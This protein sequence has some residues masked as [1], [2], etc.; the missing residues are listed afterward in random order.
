MSRVVYR[1]NRQQP[2]RIYTYIEG[3][4]FALIEKTESFLTDSPKEEPNRLALGLT[5]IRKRQGFSPKN[6]INNRPTSDDVRLSRYS[7]FP[8]QTM[9]IMADLSDRLDQAA[10]QLTLL[11]QPI[12]EHLL[13]KIQFFS[14]GTLLIGPDFNTHRRGYVIE[15]GGF[16]NEVYQYHLDLASIPI[17]VDDW[18]REQRLVKEI[19]LR[20]QRLLA[21]SLGA[22]FRCVTAFFSARVTTRVLLLAAR[23]T[24]E[25]EHLR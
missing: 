14:N 4:S 13:C 5:P 8:F 11:P 24:L 18:K 9:Y 15:T 22:E 19:F 20:Q 12:Q 6:P 7:T 1:A 2:G 21:E 17:Q 16:G 10:A 3:D 25:V 23:R